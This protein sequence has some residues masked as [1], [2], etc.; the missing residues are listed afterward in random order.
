MTHRWSSLEPFTSEVANAGVSGRFS[1]VRLHVWGPRWGMK[2]GAMLAAH[3]A[4]PERRCC[5]P[6]R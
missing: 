4:Q 1:Y 5:A 6:R 2:S 3:F